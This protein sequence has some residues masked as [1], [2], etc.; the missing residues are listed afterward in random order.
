MFESCRDRQKFNF[1]STSNGGAK[2]FWESRRGCIVVS[3]ETGTPDPGV[4]S[5]PGRNWEDDQRDAL[6]VKWFDYRV[7][8]SGTFRRVWEEM[9]EAA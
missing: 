1:S 6:R 3:Q 9:Q 4:I 7:P 2:I 5:R 8:T